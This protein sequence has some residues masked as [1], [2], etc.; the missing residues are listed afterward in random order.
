MMHSDRRLLLKGLAAAGLVISGAGWTQLAGATA[1]PAEADAAAQAGGADDVLALTSALSASAL[2]AAFIS[3]VRSAAQTVSHTTLQGLDSAPF[4][5][6]GQLLADGQSTLLVGLLDD[7]S[8]TLV[9]DLVRSAGGRVLS[10]QPLRMDSSA[11]DWAR[12][13]GQSLALGQS[14]AT[15]A[16][17]ANGAT[18]RVSF[19]CLI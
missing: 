10:E 19:R 6:L 8:A 5:R 1:K 9:L 3:G 4:Q 11:T 18:T 7:A 13:L 16:A 2:D 17:V 12:E 14:C 15:P